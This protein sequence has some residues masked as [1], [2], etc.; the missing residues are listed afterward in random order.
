M[1]LIQIEHVKEGES[2]PTAFISFGRKLD[3]WRDISTRN[4]A[5]VWL[6]NGWY[7]RI[8]LP[9]KVERVYDDP[10]NFTTTVRQCRKAA[11]IWRRTPRSKNKPVTKWSGW[12]WIPV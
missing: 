11:V 7:I 5:D 12:I 1:K 2:Y 4:S 8:I 3:R 10:V 9:F 6:K